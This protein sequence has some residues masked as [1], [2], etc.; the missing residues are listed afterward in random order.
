MFSAFFVLKGR[1]FTAANTG[2][3]GVRCRLFVEKNT[4]IALSPM[5]KT[6]IC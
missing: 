5:A 3:P 6:L 1:I 4:Q 2:R